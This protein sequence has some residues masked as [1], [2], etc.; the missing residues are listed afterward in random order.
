M[1]WDG[2]SGATRNVGGCIVRIDIGNWLDGSL[3][4]DERMFS[5]AVI[6]PR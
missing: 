2:M 3:A 5:D 1:R 6:E 4:L